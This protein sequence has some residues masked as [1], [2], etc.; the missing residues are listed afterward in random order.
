MEEQRNLLNIT[1]KRQRRVAIYKK[2][3]L[4][5]LFSIL[6][7]PI[8][9]CYVLFQEVKNLNLQL[10]SLQAVVEELDMKITV[11]NQEAEAET[12]LLEQNA[13]SD[14]EENQ[15]KELQIGNNTLEET[16]DGYRKIY[17]TF[18]DGPSKYT[19]TILDI[20]K[21]YH[22]KATFFVLGKTGEENERLYKRIVDEGHTIGLHSYS[23]QYEEIYASLDGYQQDLLKLEEYIFQITGYHSK[24]VR[25]PGGSSNTVS[26]VPM[27]VFID[28]LEKND[29]TYFDWNVASGDAALKELSQEEIVK[30]VTENLNTMQ[31]AVVLL[32]DAANRISTVEALP[33]IIEKV[34]E[35]DRTVFLPI[36][37]DTVPVQ[38]LE[39]KEE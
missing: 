7:T 22:V 6:L 34:L 30:N 16:Y 5:G 4:I 29:Y 18:D 26:D 10:Q 9:L 12:Q 39:S 23:H 21:E 2:I 17:L 28:F 1:K 24:I 3:I 25:F 27:Q 11:D 31:Q 38:H 15:S 33:V 36:T 20:L 32:H 19:D 35:L 13:F 8:I 37:E 14:V